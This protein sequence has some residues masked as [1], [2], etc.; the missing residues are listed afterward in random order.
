MT[1]PAPLLAAVGLAALLLAGCGSTD[2][3]S[4][5][6]PVAQGTASGSSSGSAAAGPV[7]TADVPACPQPTGSGSLAG[8]LPRQSLPCLDG[9]G[10]VDLAALRGPLV[11]NVWASWCPPCRA[12]LPALA[13]VARS[14][15]D[16]VAFL[17]I[18]VVDDAA[19][20][21]ALMQQLKVPYP[22]VADEQGATRGPLRWVGPPVTYFVAADGRIAGEHRGQITS[23]AVLRGLIEKYLGVTV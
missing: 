23:A 18:D 15:G 10:D 13:E 9:S 4:A 19:A 16:R 17:G 7:P 3:S 8:G 20:A 21:T 1:R 12:E 5:G 14:A 22:S 11:L 6:S 2:A